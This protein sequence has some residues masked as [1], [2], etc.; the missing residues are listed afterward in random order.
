[1]NH[2]AMHL[3]ALT[4]RSLSPQSIWAR[5]DGDKVTEGRKGRRN[6]QQE[7]RQEERQEKAEETRPTRCLFCP[8]GAA[9]CAENAQVS[10]CCLSLRPGGGN[11]KAN[12]NKQNQCP[13]TKE[14]NRKSGKET[15]A[16]HAGETKSET[17]VKQMWGS[18]LLQK[19][20]R[21]NSF[22]CTS[23][24]A[25]CAGCAQVTLVE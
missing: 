14:Q 24:G 3:L 25:V 2:S 1:M 21:V 5:T 13:K 4:H 23:G 22:F 19:S 10:L 16:S 18:E 15:Q 9:M 8:D 20:L 17:E 11:K 6:D 7:D 12:Q